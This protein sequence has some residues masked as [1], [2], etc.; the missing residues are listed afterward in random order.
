MSQIFEKKYENLFSRKKFIPTV[1]STSISTSNFKQQRLDTKNTTA[2]KS[3][4]IYQVGV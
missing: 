2:P 3:G 4:K 1:L